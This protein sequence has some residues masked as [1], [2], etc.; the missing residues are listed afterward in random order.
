VQSSQEEAPRQCVV[1]VGP[2]PRHCLLQGVV[3]EE[4]QAAENGTGAEKSRK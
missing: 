3:T 1:V 2:R 4:T